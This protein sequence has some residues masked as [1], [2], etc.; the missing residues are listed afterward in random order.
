MQSW[1]MINLKVLE[2]PII[3]YKS[4]NFR[5]LVGG[6]GGS[7]KEQIV[8]DKRNIKKSACN[9]KA[10]TDLVLLTTLYTVGE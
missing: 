2:E 10:G 4:V 6:G 9:A 3:N 7:V 1:S 5:L 8:S